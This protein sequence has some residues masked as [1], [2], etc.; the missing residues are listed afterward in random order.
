VRDPDPLEFADP[1]EGTATQGY[2]HWAL[3]V[4]DLDAAFTAVLAAGA[5]EVSAP[6]P[7]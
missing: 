2:F 1:F 7:A 3:H 4:E 5:S 6:A